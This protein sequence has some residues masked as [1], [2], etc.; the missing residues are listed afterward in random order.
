MLTNTCDDLSRRDDKLLRRR[1][2][3]PD[4][5]QMITG[6]DDMAPEI[7]VFKAKMQLELTEMD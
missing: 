1:T 2:S 3:G 7:C 6:G 5:V 4:N